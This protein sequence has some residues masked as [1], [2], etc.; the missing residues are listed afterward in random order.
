MT[1]NDCICKILV[2]STLN[3]KI[4]ATCKEHK[5]DSN[6]FLLENIL[7]LLIQNIYIYIYIRLDSDVLLSKVWLN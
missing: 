3:S 5:L 4:I 1:T 7:F 2:C 6:V